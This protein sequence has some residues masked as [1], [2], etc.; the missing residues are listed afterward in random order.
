VGQTRLI[1]DDGITIGIDLGICADH[2]VDCVV[3]KSHGHLPPFDNERHQFMLGAGELSAHTQDPILIAQEKL[4]TANIR[5]I[6]FMHA[7][8][9]SFDSK[10]T[11]CY[12]ETF[13]K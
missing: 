11:F 9:C 7:S 8:E 5:S 2:I 1:E 12:S 10:R 3:I 6:A 4:S 13:V